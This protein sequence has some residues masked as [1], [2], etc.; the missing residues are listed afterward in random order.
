MIVRIILFAT[1]ERR[2]PCALV[3]VFRLSDYIMGS[4]LLATGNNWIIFS[5]INRIVIV[6]QNPH[7]VVDTAL[8][9]DMSRF[10]MNVVHNLRRGKYIYLYKKMFVLYVICIKIMKHIQI[11]SWLWLLTKHIVLFRLDLKSQKVISLLASS[12]SKT[13]EVSIYFLPNHRN[14]NLFRRACVT[15]HTHHTIF[16]HF[17]HLEL[18]FANLRLNSFKF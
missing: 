10:N 6:Q 18:N 12:I 3:C 2:K 1:N 5:P 16:S 14:L 15:H 11:S 7:W 13:S 8:L 9:H 17:P 4:M